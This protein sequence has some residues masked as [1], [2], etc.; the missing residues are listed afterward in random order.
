MQG[1]FAQVTELGDIPAD[2]LVDALADDVAVGRE[3]DLRVVW[4]LSSR[5]L[6]AEGVLV[7]VP[8]TAASVS[9]SHATTNA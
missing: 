5:A 6:R 4:E 8:P 2:Q 1:W 9:V 7:I 3:L